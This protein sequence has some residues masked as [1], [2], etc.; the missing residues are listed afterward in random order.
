MTLRF[1]DPSRESGST[2]V[3]VAVLVPVAMFVLLFAVQACLW[4]H[5]ATLVQNA[6]TQGAQATTAL[7]ATPDSG[8]EEARRFLDETASNIVVDPAIRITHLPG[9]LIRIQVTATA[10]SIV[11]G[12]RLPV[13]AVRI[14][15]LQEFRRSA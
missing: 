14:G 13:S 3:E 6:A 1:Q 9:D 5:A 11:P 12:L 10:E 2:L 8:V 15:V 7:G 4:A